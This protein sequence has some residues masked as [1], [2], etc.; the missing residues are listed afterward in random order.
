MNIEENVYLDLTYT[1]KSFLNFTN[2]VE[3]IES[4]DSI[5]IS[6]Y[7]NDYTSYCKTLVD[8]QIKYPEKK[9]LLDC[10][11]EVFPS[12]LFG[13]LVD[14]NMYNI[15][16]YTNSLL[17]YLYNSDRIKVTVLPF[18]LINSHKYTPL[19]TEKRISKRKYLLLTG[20]PKIERTALVASLYNKD[21]LKKGYV[22][23]FGIQPKEWVQNSLVPRDKNY[24][25]LKDE[26]YKYVQKMYSEIES[27]LTL[28]ILTFDYEVAHTRTYNA[29]YYKQVDFVIVCE[30]DIEYNDY[31]FTE[32]VAKAVQLNKKFLL[33]YRQGSLA[34]VKELYKKYCN[35]DI[36][37]LTDWVDTSYDECAT[38]W[39]RIEKIVS[40]VEEEVKKSTSRL[41]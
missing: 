15:D 31:F 40:I 20:K 24:K 6:T 39:E 27:D 41:I 10:T 14:M 38:P 18:F 26:L 22:S 33:L 34:K 23:Y 4:A 13:Y 30:T 16:I 36:S 17:P 3:D 35:I 28:D 32:K 12:G 9:I 37:H 21:L 8:Y 25:V 5:V 29:D 19:L 11:T 1:G 7:F 2:Q